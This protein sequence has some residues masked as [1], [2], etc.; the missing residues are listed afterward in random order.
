MLDMDEFCADFR[1]KLA[2]YVRVYSFL[3][4]IMPYTDP[5]LE[6]LYSFGR[7]LIPHLPSD[8]DHPVRLGDE[9]SLQYYRLQRVFSG[10]I[11][12]HEDVDEYG[13]KSPTEVAAARPRMKRRPFRKS[14]NCSMKALE[15]TLQMRIVCFLSRFRKRPPTIPK[16]FSF[17]KPTHSINSN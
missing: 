9:V 11:E 6:I 15:P 17:A 1:D 7:F 12:L 4:Q 10:A 8:M 14:S 13:V 3:S 16:L 5:E 2:G